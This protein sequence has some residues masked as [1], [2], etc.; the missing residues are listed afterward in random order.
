MRPEVLQEPRIRETYAPSSTE[1]EA[2]IKSTLEGRDG[3]LFSRQNAQMLYARDAR[4]NHCIDQWKDELKYRTTRLSEMGCRYLHVVVPDKASMMHEYLD[5][6][7]S[8]FQVQ[9]R[10]SPLAELTKNYKAGLPCLISPAAYLERQKGSYPLHWLSDTRWTPWSAYMTCQLLCSSL[11]VA[12]NNQLLGYPYSEAVRPMNLDDGQVNESTQQTRLYRY[13]L[14]S[15]VRYESELVALRRNSFDNGSA[16]LSKSEFAEGAHV[17]FENHHEKASRYSVVIFGDENA[18]DSRTLITGMLAETFSEVHFV[19]AD[20]IDY[21][22]VD[23]VR[24]D[25]VITQNQEISLFKNPELSIDMRALEKKSLKHLQDWKQADRDGMQR[26]ADCEQAKDSSTGLNTEAAS[27]RVLLQSERYDLDLPV[28]VQQHSAH[29]A[30]EISMQSNE[31]T[32]HDVPFAQVYFTGPSWWV[33][34]K[35]GREII[36]HGIPTDQ[37]PAGF[38]RRGR[39]FKGTTLM[40]ATSAGAHCYYHWMTEILPKLGLLERDGVSLD[41]IDQVLVRQITGKWQIETLERFG[42]D[43]SRI[44]E[45]VKQPNLRCDRLLHIDLNCGINLKMHRFTPQWMKHLYPAAPSDEPRIKLYISRPKGVRRGIS[46]EDEFIPLL[47]EAGFTI[48]AMEGL[49]VAE[50]AA[51]LSRADVVMSPHGGGLTNMVFCRPGVKI[52]EMFSRHVFPYYWGLAANCGH[53]YYAILENP[54]EDYPRL[55]D[56]KV[57]QGF[58]DTQHSTAGLSFEV[59]IDAIKAVLDK[60]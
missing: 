37:K 22:Y 57:A 40:L 46:N 10:Y 27:S 54:E 55:V 4:A 15:K 56:S 17:V 44:V 59:S 23:R 28:M 30:A 3:W 29:E 47:E 58:A 36:R 18:A 2:A 53:H 9:D 39:R 16:Q 45:T 21:D 26:G 7:S 1:P 43:K 38:W 8:N 13:W 6:L 5:G 19:W 33:H 34:D 32:L 50:Q 49:S 20:G 31:V 52:I 42:F 60:I 25:I 48:K 12:I 11:G 35:A 24:P 51:L 41:S 14:R